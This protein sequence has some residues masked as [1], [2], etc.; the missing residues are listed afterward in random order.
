MI[1]FSQLLVVC[2]GLISVLYGLFH[3]RVVKVEKKVEEHSTDIQKLYDFNE[4]KVQ[5]IESDIIDL[6]NDFKEF[7]KEI[8]AKIHRDSNIIN[9]AIHTIERVQKVLEMH[10]VIE[11]RLE[12]IELKLNNLKKQL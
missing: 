10:E 7:K 11:D 12:K 4:L 9:Q 1:T 5:R 6:K 2:M 3:S 8:S